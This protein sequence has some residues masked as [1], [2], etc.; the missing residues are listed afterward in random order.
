MVIQC[1]SCRTVFNLDES[2]LEEE[3]TKVKCSR[4]RHIFI[5]YPTPPDLD[6]ET[7]IAPDVLKGVDKT[8]AEKTATILGESE[9]GVEKEKKVGM[10]SGLES[11]L[12]LVYQ[13]VFK[14]VD[15]GASDEKHGAAHGAEGV[16]K[17]IDRDEPQSA[18]RSETDFP[19][20]DQKDEVGAT[21]KEE[22]EP[23]SPFEKKIQKTF[24]GGRDPS[25]F[26]S[27]GGRGCR[28]RVESRSDSA[29]SGF[30]VETFF[31]KKETHGCR[32]PLSSVR[33]G[34]RGVC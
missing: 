32:R 24:H 31:G 30:Y 9:K 5:A 28:F 10:G 20:M 15:N 23:Q 14:D 2:L 25:D 27:F 21:V 26:Y 12:E 22:H 34:E 29:F 8:S 1:Q 7:V 19:S 13:D 4:C 33:I 6:D 18:G 16:F 17:E 11:D 3:G